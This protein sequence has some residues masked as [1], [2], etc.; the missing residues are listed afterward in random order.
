MVDPQ[1]MAWLHNPNQDHEDLVTA[2]HKAAPR[3]GD[4]TGQSEAATVAPTA[5]AAANRGAPPAAMPLTQLR[6]DLRECLRTGDRLVGLLAN[7]KS[8]GS[9]IK[10]EMRLIAILAGMR[11]RGLGF[12]PTVRTRRA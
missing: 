8:A 1:V 4:P 5:A 10:L 9:N 2:N 3:A 11:L 6:E 12:D 7:K